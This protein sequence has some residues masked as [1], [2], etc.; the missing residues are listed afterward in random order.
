MRYSWNG[1]ARG[2]LLVAV[3]ALAACAELPASESLNGNA[4]LA[5]TPDDGQKTARPAGENDTLRLARDVE[6]RGSIATALPLY[7]RAAAL[8][9][10]D[11]SVQVKLGDTYAKLG[12]HDDAATV[13]R[14]A[15]AKQPENGPALLGLGGILVRAGKAEEGMAM[16]AKAAP[17]VNSARAYDRLGIAHI[18]L[19]QPREALASFE[20]AHSLDGADLDITSNLTLAAALSG[21]K[22]KAVSLAKTTLENAGVQDYQRRNLLLAMC[23]VGA[24]DDAKRATTNGPGGGVGDMDA[25]IKQG[26]DIRQISTPKGRALALANARS[27]AVTN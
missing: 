24:E 11:V 19:G 12:R 23:I 15:L 4:S 14:A 16:L 10:A 18:A 1:A 9:N 8:P 26:R 2:I 22:D 20:Q 27:A 7:E 17:L 25:L 6:A 3:L 13:Y 5:G 21:H